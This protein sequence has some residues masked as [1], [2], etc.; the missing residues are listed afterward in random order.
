MVFENRKDSKRSNIV[1]AR[2]T[3]AERKVLDA[4]RAKHKLN[5]SEAIR[6]L[7]GAGLGKVA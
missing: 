6:K 7:V 4:Y 1:F 3:D 5:L 2:I